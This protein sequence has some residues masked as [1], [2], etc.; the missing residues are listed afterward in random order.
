MPP[1]SLFVRLRACLLVSLALTVGACDGAD[2]LTDPAD[3][4]TGVATAGPVAFAEGTFRGGIPIGTFA[5]PTGAFGDRFN[6]ALRNDWPQYLLKELAAIKARGGK[7]VLMFAQ[8]QQHYKDQS[9]HFDLGKW[10][11]RIDRYKGV[12][13]SS[14]VNDGTVI[15]HYLIDEP[16]DPVNWN[17]QPVP[18]SVLE[19]MAEYSKRLWPTLPTVVRAEPGYL[20]T[21]HRYLDAA[22]AQ[23]LLRK[24]TAADYLRRN[25]AEAEKKGLGLIVGMNL[26][27]G[28]PNLRE[29][30]ASELKEWGAT[31]LSGSYPCAFIS[32][33]YDARYMERSDIKE[34]M[35]FL[36][37]K[38]RSRQAKSCRGT[39]GQ[40]SGDE[41]Q[42][43]PPP[44]PPAPPSPPEPPAPPAPPE[45]PPPPSEIQLTVTQWTGNGRNYMR[46]T[47]TG[48][49]GS[50]VDVH[51]NGKL[52]GSTANDRR[53]TNSPRSPAGSKY[54]FKV[55][56]Q[57]TSTCSNTVT[58]EFKSESK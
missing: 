46:L 56:E 17:G 3:N 48:A 18:P 30:N 45:T 54:T 14:Y 19:E 32:W 15:A 22:W 41:P 2:R 53:H 47:W 33:I 16:N 20:G 39:K 24:G 44:E 50:S 4:P 25:V 49:K 21:N 11:A 51:R 23:Y 52:R 26:L 40:T 37:E 7:V 10:K 6:G 5:Q 9:G 55:C 35:D 29:I 1:A 13:F 12:N 34:A 43:P 28:G 38:A 31:L 27:K 57:G 58:A 42:L 36:A 8:S